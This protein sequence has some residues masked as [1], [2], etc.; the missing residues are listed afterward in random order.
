MSFYIRDE[1]GRCCPDC[2]STKVRY[3]EIPE[4]KR[5]FE[6]DQGETHIEHHGPCRDYC[7]MNCDAEWIMLSDHVA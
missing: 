4:S 1:S 7:C 3:V 2:K 6:D 5:E